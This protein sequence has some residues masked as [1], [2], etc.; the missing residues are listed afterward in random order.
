MQLEKHS[1]KIYILRA[2]RYIGTQ[3]HNSSRKFKLC[4]V[5]SQAA[6]ACFSYRLSD[7]GIMHEADTSHTSEADRH[8]SA[9][10]LFPCNQSSHMFIL[11]AC[12]HFLLLYIP[13]SSYEFVE[14]C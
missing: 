8:H 12:W 5:G 9:L 10:I 11:T 7:L 13:L 1:T 3:T 4:S 2:P 14:C 6:L